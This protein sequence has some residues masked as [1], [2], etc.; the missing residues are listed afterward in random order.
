MKIDFHFNRYMKGS[1]SF[2]VFIEAM[3]HKGRSVI[4]LVCDYVKARLGFAPAALPVGSRRFAVGN[5]DR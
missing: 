5:P 3:A 1:R 2:F 4:C